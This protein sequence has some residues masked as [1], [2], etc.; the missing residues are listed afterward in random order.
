MK[1][2]SLLSLCLFSVV[3]VLAFSIPN[4]LMGVLAT[5]SAASSLILGLLA[6]GAETP[7]P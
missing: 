1:K 5:L 3:A 2:S 7:K 4:V 6:R